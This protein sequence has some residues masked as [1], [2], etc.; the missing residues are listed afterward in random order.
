LSQ[1]GWESVTSGST[2]NFNALYLVNDSVGYVA[3]DNG[4]VLKTT[5]GGTSW[6]DISPSGANNLYGIYFFNEDS[7]LV[8]GQTGKIFRTVDG[9]ATWSEISSGIFSKLHTVSFY[10]NIGICGAQDQGILYS[11]DAGRTWTVFQSGFMGGGFFG[12]S[13][14]NEN[15]GF[16]GGENS[17]FQPI[18]AKT[19]NGGVNWNFSVFY[20]NNNEGRI[21]A[22]DFVNPD[23]GFAASRL[24]N[25]GGAIS[26]TTDG[27]QNWNTT[28]FNSTMSGVE[29]VAVDTTVVVYAVG[30]QGI[31]V[32]SV[33]GGGFWMFQ[34]SG[35]S[36]NLNAVQ[37]LNPDT[38]FV[39]GNGGVILRTTTGGEPPNSL[40]DEHPTEIPRTTR[41]VGNYPNPFNPSTRI[42]Y[43]LATTARVVL[44]IFDITG[45][46]IALV[47]EGVRPAGSYRTEWQ[48]GS[49]P[50]GVYFC[51]MT[52]I[53]LD[54]TKFTHQQTIKMVLL[55]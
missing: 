10:G 14:V 54:N 45:R 15:V 4:T 27:G 11:Q 23:T 39:V 6:T 32:K 30:D 36:T 1:N 25:G 29:A 38:G 53:A 9:G 43:Q 46:R 2:A 18:L 35:V 17:I 41:L 42:V 52:A 26:L 20:L 37:F 22:L 40:T 49:L 47:N 5:D 33:N 21:L 44:E 24:W 16:L 51:R 7:G 48:A 50:G 13:M 34:N 55:R 8:V 12:A 19:T 31:I 3:G 28:I